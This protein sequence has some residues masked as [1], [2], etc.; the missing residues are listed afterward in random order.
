MNSTALNSNTS[1]VDPFQM[2]LHQA[3]Q[4]Q[5]SIGWGNILRGYIATK[6]SDLQEMHYKTINV[7]KEFNRRRWENDVINNMTKISKNIWKE[8][9]DIV[10]L[11]DDHTKDTR[12][13]EAAFLL[14]CEL[15]KE[16]WK[17]PSANRAI[18][19]KP[20]SFFYESN[21]TQILNW[22]HKVYQKH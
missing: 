11:E 3:I 19:N 5:T 7:G 12:T 2:H 18:I 22:E 8:R 14:A 21:I 16:A 15:R 6:W 10:K 13:R 17:L 20:K 4:A 1:S 9:C